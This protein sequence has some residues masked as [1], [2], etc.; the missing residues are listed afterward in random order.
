[1]LRGIM[2]RFLLL[3]SFLFSC[4][5]LGW[6]QDPAVAPLQTLPINPPEKQQDSGQGAGQDTSGTSGDQITKPAGAKGST[7]IGCLSGPSKDGNFILRSMKYR[8]G[9]QVL[10]GDDLKNDSGSKVKLTGQ[11]E[12]PTSP[13]T[14]ANSP[15]EMR[16]F[17][18]T[19]VEVLGQKCSVPIETT[20]TSKTKKQNP[21]TY[22]APT[23]DSS[24]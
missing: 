14:D 22:N 6:A 11:W 13:Q 17:Q 16:R 24:H 23:D 8:T 2:K 5:L 15:T 3:T 7:L 1:M 10:G 19:Q 21:T 18:V 4:C 12:A 9:V 20:P